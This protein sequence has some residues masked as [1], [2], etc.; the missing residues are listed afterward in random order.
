[1]FGSSSHTV[2][3]E[4]PVIDLLNKWTQHGSLSEAGGIL[5]GYRRG[6]HLHVIDCTTPFPDD[7]RSRFNFL[8]RDSRHSQTALRRWAETEHQAYYLG[9]WHTHPED[10]PTP[11]V[12][13]KTGWKKLMGSALGP[14]V[15]FLIVGRKKW[16][17]QRGS[18]LLTPL[19]LSDALADNNV[20]LPVAHDINKG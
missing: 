18:T 15:L 6:N 19:Q 2:L 11:S 5:V 12:T 3:I 20:E 16:Y 9:E 7:R 17:V 14:D 4:S 13:D 10:F 8:R 1:M